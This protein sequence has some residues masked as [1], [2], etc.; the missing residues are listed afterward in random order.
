MPDKRFF[1]YFVFL[2]L[3]L[4]CAPFPV[5]SDDKCKSCHIEQHDNWA[6]SHHAG[7][8]QVATTDSV[9]GDFSGTAATHRSQTATFFYDGHFKSSISDAGGAEETF[10]IAYTFGFSPLQQYL[11]K[12]KQ[13]KYQ[14]LPF[15][16]DS[17][18]KKEG[19]Q[20]WFH[21]YPED[22]ILKGDRL[23]WQQPLQNW[24]GM[25]ADC[26]S[27]GL[28]RNYD[29]AADQFETTFTTE[30]VS[31]LSCHGGAEK[32]AVTKKERPATE[33]SWQD[34]LIT[35]LKDVDGF[36]FKPGAHT[37]SWTGAEPRKRPEM[38]IC[39][40]CHSLR[41][42]LTDGIDPTEKF[43]DQFAP[44]FLDDPFY[45]PDGQIREE[46]YVWG[47][48]QQSKMF[49]AGVSC[50]DCHDSH[51]LKLKAEGNNLCTQCHSAPVFDTPDH[52]KHPLETKGAKCVS[53][54]MPERT[55]MVVDPRRDHSFKIPKP[56]VSLITGS[57]NTCTTCH[58]NQ[59]NTWAQDALAGWF[60]QSQQ[61]SS[62]AATFNHARK[63]NPKARAG[64]I[65]II[66]DVQQAPIV[67]ATAL[68]LI[69][70]VATQDLIE[71]ARPYLADG[72]P[73]IRM[74]AI[75]AFAPMPPR[76][77]Y[78][79]LKH[80]L[81]DDVR[82]V[83]IEA[84]RA[85]L[86]VPD[87]SFTS[88]AF[89]ELM[90]ADTIAS[91]RGEGRANLALHHVAKRDWAQAEIEYR[92]AIAQDPSFA[93]ALINLAELLRQSGRENEAHA[94]LKNAALRSN[95]DASVYHSLGLAQVRAGQKKLAV[96]SLE[97]AA[98]AAPEVARYTYVY[99]VALNSTGQADA[100]YKG[101]KKALRRHRYDRDI[102]Q[103]ALGLARKRG[104]KVY[105]DRLAS[106]LRAL[107]K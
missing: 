97:K 14:V 6:T 74:G 18:P 37:A 83:R 11:V 50:F 104:D 32:H 13:G 100:A 19:G 78:E 23:H 64:L 72:S 9:L 69:A 3:C 22:T 102:L 68:S 29:A 38:E 63:A 58:S 7:A 77:L 99:L 52:H 57:P 103:F 25:C 66:R 36:K 5:I 88:P 61:H 8:M 39:A 21:I 87:I 93:P 10:E 89:I 51:S 41:A 79:T 101:V 2:Y 24:N 34:R 1:G 26:H 43:L 76:Q 70:R 96:Q 65:A 73:L 92:K 56:D 107:S 86:G 84:A 30:N 12:T 45:F 44:T 67:R 49:Q 16:W 40:A 75:R 81:S 48:F 98:K 90:Q 106:S 20:R 54:H 31:C 33:D 42:P 59:T 15:A 71:E 4:L 62:H 55:Y 91:W 53:C 46:V 28:K 47:S 82:A 95:A 105:A 35:Y 85:L 27:T 60:P 94:L 80:L 17:R